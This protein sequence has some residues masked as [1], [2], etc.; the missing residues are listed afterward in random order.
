MDVI[1]DPFTDRAPTG[2]M[3]VVS[4]PKEAGGLSKDPMFFPALLLLAGFAFLQ[5]LRA[6][7]QEA[8]A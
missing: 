2:P 1:Q 3:C 4:A 7:K 8:T 5:T 6:R